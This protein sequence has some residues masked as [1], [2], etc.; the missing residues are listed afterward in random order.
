MLCLTVAN[1]NEVVNGLYEALVRVRYPG[2]TN[3]E[4]TDL[5]NSLLAQNDRNKLLHWLLVQSLRAISSTTDEPR[6]DDGT[7]LKF[8]F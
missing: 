5:E 3:I 2:V 4:R 8:S 1:I 6:A 7:E